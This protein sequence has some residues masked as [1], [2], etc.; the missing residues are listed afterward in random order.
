[1][2]SD[3]G[4]PALTQALHHIVKNPCSGAQR[5]RFRGQLVPIYLPLMLRLASHFLEVHN[6]LA[7]EEGAAPRE[8]VDS[9]S[10]PR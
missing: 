5:L 1:M 9:V 10:K 4:G 6:S 8:V 7:I 3:V 2:L